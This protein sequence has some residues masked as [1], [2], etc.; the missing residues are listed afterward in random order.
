MLDDDHPKG[1][2]FKKKKKTVCWLCCVWQLRWASYC[3]S[4]FYRV[5]EKKR[6]RKEKKR[7]NTNRELNELGEQ[8]VMES[9][10]E[11][12]ETVVNDCENKSLSVR[13]HTVVLVHSSR[14]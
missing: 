4:S 13:R 3:S 14:V 8:R 2:V 9:A 5:L 12:K 7:K 10:E 11:R 6:R 1:R